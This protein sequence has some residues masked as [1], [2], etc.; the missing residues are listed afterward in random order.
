MVDGLGS[1]KFQL[2]VTNPPYVAAGDPHLSQGDLRF[3]PNS[4]LVAANK[5]FADIDHIIQQAPQYLRS[6]GALMIEHGFQQAQEIRHIFQT[7]GYSKVGSRK[8]LAGNDRVT[9]GYKL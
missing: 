4:A 8:D 5:G 7:C 3:E 9:F 1:Q 6:N 2:I